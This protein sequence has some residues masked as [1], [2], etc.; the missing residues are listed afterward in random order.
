MSASA[1]AVSHPSPQGSAYAG[2]WPR[3]WAGLLDV[4]ILVPLFVFFDWV[5]ASSKAGA[6]V[7]LL[8]STP[9]Y[10]MYVLGFHA[11]YGQTPGKMLMRIKIVRLD[12]ASIGWS[13]S[14]MRS[15]VDLGFAIILLT[16]LLVAL[17]Q[18]SGSEY[19]ALSWLAQRDRMQSVIPSW[20]HA[21]N[22]LWTIWIYSEFVVMLLNRRR[23]AIHDFI[24]GTVV[25]KSAS[26]R[27]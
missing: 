17:T 15:L 3:L 2:F 18:I 7:S 27:P 6:I 14:W 22:T 12:G 19:A 21:A 5:T 11:R 1:I 25:V 4:L 16:G 10:W 23:R 24:A 9:L 8:I 20:A 13:E 26:L